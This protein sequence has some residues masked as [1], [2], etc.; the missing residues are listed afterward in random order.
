MYRALG[1]KRRFGI[2]DKDADLMNAANTKSM[3]ETISEEDHEGGCIEL[4]AGLA[5]ASLIKIGNLKMDGDL[6]TNTEIE[7]DVPTH[8][9]WT[10]Q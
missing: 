1:Q 3:E 8:P 10:L 6:P 4:P 9:S 2:L 7:E 5:A